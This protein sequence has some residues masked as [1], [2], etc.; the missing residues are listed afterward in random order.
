[1][2]NKKYITN[3]FSINIFSSFYKPRKIF[4]EKS[5][6]YPP[7]RPFII[8]VQA[9]KD[10]YSRSILLL[11]RPKNP[12]WRTRKRVA[13]MHFL[14][15]FLGTYEHLWSRNEIRIT[16]VPFRPKF[17]RNFFL[18]ADLSLVLTNSTILPSWQLFPRYNGGWPLFPGMGERSRLYICRDVLIRGHK[19]WKSSSP[20]PR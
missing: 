13:R 4:A 1:M 5:Q 14:R 18:S 19:Y 8:L 11:Q 16:V 20:F 9:L 15:E 10:L 12:K 6:L 7:H 17:L 3:F 2:E